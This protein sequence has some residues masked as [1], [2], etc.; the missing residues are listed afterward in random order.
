M[1]APSWLQQPKRL[2][3]RTCNPVMTV[4]NRFIN[5]TV[6]AALTM[7]SEFSRSAY[8]KSRPISFGLHVPCP[9]QTLHPIAT[10]QVPGFE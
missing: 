8:D 6:A 3:A 4:I 9:R 7:C 2:C 5:E 10:L 1:C